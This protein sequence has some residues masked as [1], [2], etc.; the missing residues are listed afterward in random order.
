MDNYG[1]DMVV[2]NQ[3]STHR[4]KVMIYDKDRKKTPFE[5]DPNSG[6]DVEENYL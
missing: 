5:V 2:A 6:I 4:Y 1:V 3:L